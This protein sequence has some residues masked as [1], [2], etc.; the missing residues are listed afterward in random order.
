M[1]NHH[2]YKGKKLSK[3][4]L[5]TIAGGLKKCFYAGACLRISEDCAEPQCNIL[6]DPA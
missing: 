5:R 1:K 4:E 2:L 6:H 3:K